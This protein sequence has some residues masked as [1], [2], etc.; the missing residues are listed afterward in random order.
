MERK[1]TITFNSE[2]NDY[3]NNAIEAIA[4]MLGLLP[5]ESIIVEDEGTE[6]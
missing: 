4:G 1:V 5:F 6:R 2:D 3:I